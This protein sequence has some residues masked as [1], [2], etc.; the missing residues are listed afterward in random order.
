MILINIHPEATNVVLGIVC[1]RCNRSL[2]VVDDETLLAQLL[3]YLD[4]NIQ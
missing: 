1:T 2:V 3:D 4:R